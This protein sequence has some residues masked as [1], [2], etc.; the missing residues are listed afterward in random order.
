MTLIV[1]VA[2][3]ALVVGL[4]YWYFSRKAQD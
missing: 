4:T 2:V 3:A 1:L